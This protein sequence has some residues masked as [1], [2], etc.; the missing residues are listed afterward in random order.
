MQETVKNNLV[1]GTRGSKLALAQAEEVKGLLIEAHD[2]LNEDNIEIKVMSTRG[3]RVQDRNLSEIGG[4]GLFTEEIEEALYEG[5]IDIAVHSLKDMPTRLPEGLE[6]VCYLEREDVKDAFLSAKANSLLDLPRGAVLG[7]SSL[8]RKAQALYLRPDLKVVNF[9]GNV[10]TRLKKLD[11]NVADATFL[12]MAGL[13]RLGIDDKR[14][15]PINTA[16]ILPAVAQGAITIEIASKN[17]VMR[18]ILKP[19]NHEET[20]LRVR[21]ERTM[22][23]ILDG[24]CRTP[25]AG[26][27]NITGDILTLEGRVLNE[28][29]TNERKNS[30]SGD[31][32]DPE[33]IGQELGQLLKCASS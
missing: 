5:E 31:K 14:V 25:I 16:E 9:R 15:I 27:A 21:A 6:L 29:G 23:D 10:Q 26:L 11:D 32:Y 33:A 30:V 12:A 19:L 8:R 7:T 4:K 20:E 28:D 24:S 17:D 18:S 2:H 1:I 22:L 3:D 13:N